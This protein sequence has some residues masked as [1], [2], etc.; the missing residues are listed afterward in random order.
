MLQ[1]GDDIINML[2]SDGE[3]NGCRTDTCLKQ[4]CLVQLR[5]GGAGWVYHERLHIGHIRQ[6]REEFKTFSKL[7]R[8]IFRTF[9]IE[10][11]DRTSAFLE[12]FVVQLFLFTGGYYYYR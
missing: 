1:V 8:I 2:C 5:M 10:G 3:A 7:S 11:E 6:E 9:D 12:V 4:L